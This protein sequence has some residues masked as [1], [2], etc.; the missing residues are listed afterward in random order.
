MRVPAAGGSARAATTTGSRGWTWDPRKSWLPVLTPGRLGQVVIAGHGSDQSVEMSSPGTGAWVDEQNKRVG[1]DQA[2]IDSKNDPSK[3]G[4]KLLFDT[5]I[6]RMDPADVNIVFAGCL[7]GSHDIP[8]NTKVSSNTATTQKNLQDAL[9]K[10]P[11]LADY[12]RGRISAAGA[13]GTVQACQRL[14]NV[15]L[16]RCRSGHRQ[17]AHQQPKRTRPRRYQA[18]IPE[19]RDRT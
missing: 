6:K 5:V 9:K 17:G 7:V 3:N 1:Y 19:D 11:N 16:V 13:T 18:G 12:V 14:R 2:D 4:T 8:Q 15:R 10:H